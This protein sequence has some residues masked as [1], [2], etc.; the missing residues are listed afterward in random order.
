MKVLLDEMLPAGV[1][2]ILPKHDVT[3]VKSAGYAGLLNGDL[4]R[5][6][7]A[8]GF[9]VLVTADRSMPAQQNILTS[10]IAVVLVPGNRVSDIEP[11]A[12]SIQEAIARARPGT[13]TRIAP[14][15]G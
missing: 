8:A 11:Y 4:I 7:A 13:V 9:R 5:A 15:G 12:E 14:S 10:G 1:A 6:A 3:T 2:A